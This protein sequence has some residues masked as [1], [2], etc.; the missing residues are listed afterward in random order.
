MLAFVRYIALLVAA[1]AVVA[2]PVAEVGPADSLL[3]TTFVRG[4]QPL[5]GLAAHPPQ[6]ARGV[7]YPPMKG[8]P[9]TPDVDDTGKDGVQLPPMVKRQVDAGAVVEAVNVAIDDAVGVIDGVKYPPMCA[10]GTVAAA[11]RRSVAGAPVR[12][13]PMVVPVT[14]GDTLRRGVRYPPME[15]NPGSK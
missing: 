8:L 6:G 4:F 10:P 5:S 7:T 13:H 11:V 14:T 3:P 9:G 2:L 15:C 12:L 1:S